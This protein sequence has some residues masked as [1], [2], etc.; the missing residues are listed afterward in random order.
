VFLISKGN[1]HILFDTSSKKYG[2]KLF[3]N[4][5]RM[6]IISI[7]A[8]IMSHTHFDHAGNAAEIKER[9]NPEILVHAKEVE[10]LEDGF[11]PVPPGTIWITRLLI[12]LLAGKIQSW[13][14]YDPCKP[15]IRVGDMYELNTFGL[16]ARLLHTP[17]HSPGMIS[18]IVD[19]EIALVGDALFGIFPGSVFPPFAEN[20]HQLLNSWDRL[21]DTGCRLYLPAHGRPV[22]RELLKKCYLKK[23]KIR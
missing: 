20:V 2:K 18:L 10:W 3:R 7:Q 11:A 8:L 5:N 22:P 4:L 17:G 15:D 21:L 23:S 9:F 6:K 1:N 19:D 16:N 12:R 13:F 14:S